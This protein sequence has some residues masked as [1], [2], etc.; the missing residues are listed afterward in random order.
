VAVEIDKIEEGN[1]AHKITKGGFWDSVTYFE[2]GRNE[3]QFS[4]AFLTAFQENLFK[5]HGPHWKFHLQPFCGLSR[6][7]YEWTQLNIANDLQLA[8]TT[9]QKLP[10]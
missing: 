3:L 9:S 10:K 7:P 1:V 5:I 4:G 6:L 2:N 8:V